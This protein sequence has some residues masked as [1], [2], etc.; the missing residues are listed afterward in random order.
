[1]IKDI[2]KKLCVKRRQLY[3]NQW[4]LYSYV[5]GN[6]HLDIDEKIEKIFK[7]I[8]ADYV[9]F[10]RA[11]KLYD[12]TDL[13]L[14]L[15]D[16]CKEY[17]ETI[18]DSPILFVDEFQDIDPIQ[19]Q[20]FDFVQTKRRMYIGDP[21]QAIYAFRGACSQVF[22]EFRNDDWTWFNLS[23]NYRSKQNIIDFAERAYQAASNALLHKA[24]Y[25]FIRATEIDEIP[26][27]TIEAS[28]GTGGAVMVVEDFCGEYLA[29]QHWLEMSENTT[30]AEIARLLNN[31]RTQILC[32]SNKQVKKLQTL[33]IEN[34]STVHQAKGLE[35]DTVIMV[36]FPIST[37]E[38][39]NISYVAATRAKN[40][41][42]II[43]WDML[44]YFV[45]NRTEEE[46]QQASKRLF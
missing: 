45:A 18:N 34:V 32:R 6:Y 42:C 35:Y 9:H 12:F 24:N 2:L 10:K 43:D 25:S 33:G 7:I 17:D 11:N 4:L 22:D 3:I 31:P 27:S 37:E 39:L 1:M 8:S 23:T 30:E 19:L 16:V 13:P 46:K 29:E 40:E 20:V 44:L 21:K 28:R 14:Y 38:E 36:E 15:C 5:M 41:L 26:I